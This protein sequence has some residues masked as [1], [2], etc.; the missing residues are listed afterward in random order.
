[1]IWRSLKAPFVI[2]RCS[3][4]EM[5]KITTVIR[6]EDRVS[7]PSG[8]VRSF[9]REK[10]RW[11]FGMLGAYVNGADKYFLIDDILDL[12]GFYYQNHKF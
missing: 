9:A 10:N 11:H 2:G 6:G 8:Q 7:T 4:R 3:Q 12:V 1:M 5:R